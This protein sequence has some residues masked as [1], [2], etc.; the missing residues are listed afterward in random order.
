MRIITGS[1]RGCRL[2]APK[3]NGTRPTS[4]RIKESLFSVLGNSVIGKDVLDLFAGT[5][6]LGLE[7][8]SRGAAHGFF[9]DQTT[10]H[11]IRENA[12]HARL[13]EKAEICKRDVFTA[14]SRLSEE[15]RRFQLIFCDPPYGK[16]LWERALQILDASDI[17]SEG[18]LFIAEHGG[19]EGNLPFSLENFSL[20]RELHYGKTT[21][22]SIYEKI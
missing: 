16:G 21:C 2:K 14:L 13:A 4:D 5:G 12:E 17:M 7:A 1:A 10:A 20:K 19:Q 3:G 11:I 15:K 18:G 6:A 8:L 22:I 9:V